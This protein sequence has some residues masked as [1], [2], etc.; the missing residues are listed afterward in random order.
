MTR[1]GAIAVIASVKQAFAGDPLTDKLDRREIDDLA[2]A[3]VAAVAVERDRPETRDFLRGVTLEAEH[4]RARWGTAHD[5]GKEPEDWLFLIGWLA[6]KACAAAR[7][8]DQNKALHHTISSAA[9]LANWHLA[10]SG[11]DARMRPGIDPVERKVA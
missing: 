5:A 1:D 3:F 2:E 10:L 7:L 6:G 4:Q 9:A 11:A 8:G